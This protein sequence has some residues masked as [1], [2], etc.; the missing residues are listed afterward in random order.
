MLFFCVLDEYPGNGNE[1][2][3]FYF[4]LYGSGSLGR[5]RTADLM[6]N[7]HPLYR[8]SYQGMRRNLKTIPLDRQVYLELFFY[9]LQKRVNRFSASL[10][11]SMPVAKDRR[12]QPSVPNA[13][14]GTMA[15]PTWLS[16]FSEN[17]RSFS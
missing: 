3:F 17:S 16:N 7:S 6:I 15:K 9:S 11:V 10:R 1:P 4:E 5:A 14:P 12:I 13:D 2:G 8:L